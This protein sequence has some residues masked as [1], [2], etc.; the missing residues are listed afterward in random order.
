[1]S[2][3]TETL[4]IAV[5]GAGNVG[6]AL[7]QIWS[8]N[9]H[10]VVFGARDPQKT[11]KELGGK[12]EVATN[13]EA[14]KRSTVVV[15]SVPWPAAQAAIID[16]GDL[17][18]KVLIDCTNPL[19]P[20]LKDLAVGCTTSAGEL[21]ASWAPRARV[22]KAFNTIGAP[23]FGNAQFGSQRA[24]GFYC[25]DDL[26]AKNVVK[27]LIEEVGLDPVDIGPLHSARMLEP[28]ALLWID[29]AI[30]Q[31]QGLNHGFKLLRR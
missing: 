17:D 14:A 18:G 22:V 9:G 25:G 6:G 27:P 2:G 5:L 26:E 13:R 21:V 16:A 30:N 23:D 31:K 29:L 11:S 3:M 1:M 28:L 4:S 10:Q 7:G 19:T 20:D 8:R 12:A 24:D 15:L